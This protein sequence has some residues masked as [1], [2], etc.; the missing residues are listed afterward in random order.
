M[1]GVVGHPVRL[2]R[3]GLDGARQYLGEEPVSLRSRGA[4]VAVG[5]SVQ[6]AWPPRAAAIGGGAFD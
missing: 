2:G 6:H 5:R 4:N 1:T 3:G